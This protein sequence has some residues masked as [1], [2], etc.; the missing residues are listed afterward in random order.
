MTDRRLFTLILWGLVIAC[1]VLAVI[2]YRDAE[3]KVKCVVS[4][5]DQ[6]WPAQTCTREP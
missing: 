1:L 6:G 2:T 3:P 4:Y 5:S